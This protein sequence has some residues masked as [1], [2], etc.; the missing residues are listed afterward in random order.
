M[1]I[2]TKKTANGSMR[3]VVRVRDVN[4]RWFQARTFKRKVDAQQHERELLSSRDIGTEALCKEQRNTKVADLFESWWANRTGKI[5]DGWHQTSR[6]MAVDYILPIIGEI[7]VS[8]VRP[9]HIGLVITRMAEL[10]RKGQTRLHVYQVLRHMFESAVTY[11]K[12]IQTNPVHKT[13][14]PKAIRAE[15]RFLRLE[16]S[17]KLFAHVKDH[18]LGI[19]I[20]LGLLVGLR[21]SEI[22]ALRWESV[23]LSKREIIIRAAYKIRSKIIEDFPKGGQQGRVGIPEALLE[24]LQIL[25]IGKLGSDFVAPAARG[26]MLE[27]KKFH[28]GLKKLCRAAGVTEISPHGLRH[29]CTEIWVSIGSSVEDIRRQLNQKSP[30]T[31]MGY[32]HKSDDRVK[33]LAAKIIQ[34]SPALRIVN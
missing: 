19:A 14:R 6:Q 29:S 24:Y 34:P 25:S 18:Y 33:S 31:T 17:W 32:I 5:S 26:G 2:V 22:Q 20:S 9:S 8:D 23:D 15:P 11:Y 10:G 28:M 27:Q 1:A 7:K 13:D 3:Y 16:E 12:I 21:T 4:G 30:S